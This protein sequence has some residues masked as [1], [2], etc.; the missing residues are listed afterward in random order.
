MTYS[1]QVAW[2]MA[3]LLAIVFVGKVAI[4]CVRM[5]MLARGQHA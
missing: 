1:R 5:I 3:L 2:V 4:W